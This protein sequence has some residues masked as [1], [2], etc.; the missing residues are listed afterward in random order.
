M[1]R[2]QVPAPV[3]ASQTKRGESAL[4]LLLALREKFNRLDAAFSQRP[5]PD[6]A[7]DRHEDEYDVQRDEAYALASVASLR[8]NTDDGAR[9]ITAL[10]TSTT[11][12]TIW[13]PRRTRR[14]LGTRRG[15]HRHHGDG[16]DFCRPPRHSFGTE[17]AA[18]RQPA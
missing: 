6:L 1:L 8:G 2:G 17:L 4:P 12:M 9:N 3:E 15:Y 14:R 11:A 7:S 10:Q 16:T 5:P 18:K 13:K